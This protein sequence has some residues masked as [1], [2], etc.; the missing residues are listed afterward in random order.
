M[1]PTRWWLFLVCT[2]VF[3]QDTHLVFLG[4]GNPNPDPLRMGP[5]VAVISADRVYLVDCGP[6]VVRRAAQAGIAMRQL[7]RAFI[8]HLHSDHTVGYP[9][10]IFTPAVAGRE[11]GLEVYG[12]PGLEAMTKHIMAAWSE[13]MDVRLHGLEPS[14]PEAYVVQAHDV[15]PGAVYR[16]G[17]MR[18]IAFPVQ[19]GTWKHAYGYRFEAK[20]K[21]IVISGDT[22]AS[23]TLV[24]AAKG[25]DILVHEVYSAKA[26][27]RRTPD[28]RRYHSAFHTSGVD[29]GKIAAKVHPRKLV[30]YHAMLMGETADELIGEIR[31][32]YKGEITYAS[33]LDVVR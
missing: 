3:A 21:T 15:E 26:L 24:D 9:D 6:G 27:E 4:T 12:P 23:E 14:R 25:C 10:L 13:D 5:S 17:V 11:S 29:L 33:D 32:N 2:F 18:V 8:T 31:E 22:T 19:H 7:T 28:W 30:L 1:L 16:D 20:D